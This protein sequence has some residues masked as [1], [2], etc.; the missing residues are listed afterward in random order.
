MRIGPVRNSNEV[1]VYDDHEKS[2]TLNSFFATVGEKLPSNFPTTTVDGLSL[3]SRIIPT[4]SDVSFGHEVFCS[5]LAKLNI[6]KSHGSDGITSKEMK[7]VSKEIAYGISN[8]SKMS[9][10]QG[11]YPSQWKIGKVK[12]CADCG[13]YRPLTMLCIPSKV[14]ESV[15]CDTIDPRLNDVLHDNQ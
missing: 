5:K 11:K 6:L 8:L 10:E 7:I 3:I 1:F 13:N 4:I 15:L 9:Y 2:A 14:V 12:D